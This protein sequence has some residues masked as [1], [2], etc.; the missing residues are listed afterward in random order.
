MSHRAYQAAATRAENPRET[1]YRLFGEV[2]RALMAV[3]DA[4][5]DRIRERAEALDRNRRMWGAFA[6]DCAAEGNR[7]PDNLRAG[8]ISLSIYIT[9]ITS[10][11]LRNIDEFDELIALNRTVMQGLAP[12]A[13][14]GDAA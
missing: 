9:K 8:I 6:A 10:P 1:E 13:G 7:L 3:R 11:A 12:G 14:R 2:T 5:P 4:G